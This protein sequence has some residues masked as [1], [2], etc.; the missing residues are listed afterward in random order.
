MD[1]KKVGIKRYQGIKKRS[2][3]DHRFT[4]RTA[5]PGGAPVPLYVI[6]PEK[7]Y[8]LHTI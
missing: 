1:E 8:I 6:H 3:K 5:L 7:N 4:T 2:V